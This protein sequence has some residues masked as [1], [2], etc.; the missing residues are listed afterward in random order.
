MLTELG[1]EQSPGQRR[2][3]AEWV[4]SPGNPLTARVFVNRVWQHHFGRGIVR[5]SDNFGRAGD[6]PT[7]PELLDWLARNFV[8]GGYQ[9]KKLHRLI[10]M[11]NAYRMSSKADNATAY[12]ADPGNDLFWRQNLRRLDAEAIRD[13]VLAASGR[14]NTAMTGRGIFPSLSQEVLATQS[15]PGHGW[16]KSTPVEEDRRS[17]YIF[18][19]RTL[20]VPMLEAF[21]YTNTAES[22]GVRP[23][24]T[25][26][27]QALMLLNSEFL[28]D[29]S[30][31]LAER[32]AREA[33]STD[34]EFVGSAFRYALGREPSDQEE[35]T[36]VQLLERQRRILGAAKAAGGPKPDS[37]AEARR[38]LCLVLLNLNEFVYVD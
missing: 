23:T 35:Q 36:A 30:V 21:D 4:V 13:S 2:A 26:A 25:V 17:V 1:V 9:V 11:S 3:F 5:S 27:P 6:A 7:H 24:T 19:K 32:A 29:Q 12:K 22:L 8:D 16:G 10:M 34:S 37:N 28:R 20:M 14:L 18:V 31:A 38:S 33:G 15:K